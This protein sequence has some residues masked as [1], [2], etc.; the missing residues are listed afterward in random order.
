MVTAILGL[1]LDLSLLCSFEKGN[2]TAASMGRDQSGS[3]MVK[4]SAVCDTRPTQRAEGDAWFGRLYAPRF[5]SEVRRIGLFGTLMI[6]PSAFYS[7]TRCF[8]GGGIRVIGATQHWAATYT[9]WR[10]WVQN[11]VEPRRPALV[12]VAAVMAREAYSLLLGGILDPRTRFC[13]FLQ[14]GEDLQ[15][16]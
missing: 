5:Q 12:F 16:A 7:Q 1:S 13:W 11:R 3:T 2:A 14:C 4:G 10:S 15:L 6:M 9:T 8:N